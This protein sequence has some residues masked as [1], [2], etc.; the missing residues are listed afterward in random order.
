MPV[1]RVR[2]GRRAPLHH[3]HPMTTYR[4]GQRVRIEWPEPDDG[5]VME[6]R[7]VLRSM[8]PGVADESLALDAPDAYYW[9]STVP[10]NCTVTILSEP[11]PDEPTGLGAV[12][13]AECDGYLGL[14]VRQRGAEVARN[15][16][17]FWCSGD[18]HRAWD[19]LINPVVMSEGWTP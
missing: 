12:V 7:L 1:V 3:G 5:F 16:G 14:W 4:A 13:R 10:G 8:K 17:W 15:H 18:H 11:R 6:G 2:L 19:E 9:L